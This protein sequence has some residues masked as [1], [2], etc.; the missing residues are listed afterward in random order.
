MKEE[1]IKK[2]QF[3]CSCGNIITEEDAETYPHN[4]GIDL[5]NPF[6]EWLYFHCSKCEYDWAWWKIERRLGFKLI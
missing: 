1:K 2:F 4:G 6:K 5:G 3:K